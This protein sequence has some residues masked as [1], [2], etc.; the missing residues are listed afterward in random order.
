[1]SD[2]SY[3]PSIYKAQ[4]GADM[5]FK[6]GSTLTLE[7]GSTLSVAGTLTLTGSSIKPPVVA[8]ANVVGGIAVVHRIAVANGS[9]ANTD[10]VLTNKTH[11][12]DVVVIKT[13]GAGGASDTITVKNGTNAITNAMD[14]NVADKAVVRASTIDDAYYEIAAGGTLRV[15]M[16]NGAAGGN[17][18]AC[19]VVVRGFLVS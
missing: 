9:T 16:V 4:G 10:V 5:V 8:D 13:A 2:A 1:M 7:S 11:I 12:F 18:T 19:E 14:I 17:N 15:A 6:T 3:Q